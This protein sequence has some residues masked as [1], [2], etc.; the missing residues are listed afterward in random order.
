MSPRT[1]GALVLVLALVL[2][3]LPSCGGET[4]RRVALWHSYRGDEET[5]LAEVAHR[6]EAA[7]PDVEVELLGLPF[8]AYQSKLKAAIPHGHGPHVFIDAHERVAPY[9]RDGFVAEVALDPSAYD[10][11]AVAAVTVAGKVL[12]QPLSEKALA[13]F[14]R[15]DVPPVTTFEELLAVPA[16]A[17]GYPVVWDASGAFYHQP[18]LAS[19]GGSYVQD[20]RY[21][22]DEPA[23]E[24]SLRWLQSDVAARGL[25]PKE[26]SAPV[27]TE[28]FVAGKAN[29]LIE[30]PWQLATLPPELS[31]RVV[32]L[33]TL[34]GKPMRPF[35]AVESAFLTPRG[36]EDPDARALIAFLGSREAALVLATKGHQVVA[37]RDAWDDP[38]IASSATL[39]AFHRA[40]EGGVLMPATQ[41]MNTAWVPSSDAL[42]RTV[43][44]DDP[45]AALAA[46]H[47]RW[48]EANAP[49]PP[50][51]S[52]GPLYVVLGL[53]TLAG[54]FFAVRRTR[55]PS[56]RRELRR[57]LPAY[58]WV[59]HA[60]VAVALLVIV[61]LA[62]GALTS[63]YSGTRQNP[64]YVGL[65]NYLAI[66]GSHE[67]SF[68]GHG[69]FW[70]TLGVTVLWTVTNVALHLAL[71]LGLGLLLS[72]PLLKLRAFYR[73]LLV[74]P[75]A[76]PSYV[77]ALAWKG[78]FHGQFG[79]I[80]AVLVALGCQP[81]SWFEKFS[82]AFA[83]N[84]ATN[85]WLGF[86]FMMVVTLGALTSIPKDVL[87]AAE[88][89][90][91]TRWQ[92]F[93]LVT[94]PL[95]KPSL[96]PAVILGAVWTFNM[97]NVVFLVSGG[98]P[99]GKTDILVS[100]AYRW[101]FTRD[102]QY[103]YG[104]AY[105]VLIFLLLF[106]TSRLT[107]TKDEAAAR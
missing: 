59:T 3:L 57:S 64:T 7:H 12:A 1:R 11:N 31:Y 62:A 79:A 97:F 32:P 45:H 38:T 90:G 19:F 60:A 88:V 34:H 105:A 52:P 9:A 94:L 67:G 35:V 36:A 69:S 37:R 72:R 98:E 93:R 77:T 44:G 30:G 16:P 18:F 107:S 6:F 63:F 101:A 55:D 4:K 73:V 53:L 70:V 56:F 80:N 89:D 51:K 10:P 54:A 23:G 28:L 96:L 82:T 5:A 87:E 33:P 58:K 41:A 104:A 76:V 83:A 100:D 49:P 13:L 92:R 26:P 47:R 78:M 27:A 15:T 22:F 91:A 17:G 50:P 75:W 14:V 68:F 40:A 86:P 43:A 84:V 65:A 25:L 21:T 20:A 95:L 106:A 103:G 42:K 71:G 24:A 81:V 66:L 29:A 46:A 85:V 99:D 74:L 102:T 8:D 39:A 61:P 2:A 48:D